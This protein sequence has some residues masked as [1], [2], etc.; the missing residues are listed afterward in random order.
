MLLS[1]HVFTNSSSILLSD[2]RDAIQKKTFTK[3]A[4]KHLK[5][6]SQEFLFTIYFILASHK[7]LW[8]RNIPNDEQWL[9]GARR[10]SHELFEGIQHFAFF[11]L[12]RK[13]HP[14][15]DKE[16]F[17]FGNDIMKK[18]DRFAKYRRL[19][20][21]VA[22]LWKSLRVECTQHLIL[23]TTLIHSQDLMTTAQQFFNP[24]RN[25]FLAKVRNYLV[26]YCHFNSLTLLK[27]AS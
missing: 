27:S 11:L 16:G 1:H 5:K 17:L 6:V 26:A 2:E 24:W 18:P 25:V 21:W 10:F 7:N 20:D 14:P 13:W 3:W 8:K 15:S 12:C 9:Q 19:E 23:L 22:S 4:N